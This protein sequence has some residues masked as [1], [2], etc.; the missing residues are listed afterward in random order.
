MIKYLFTKGGIV[1]TKSTAANSSTKLGLHT[2]DEIYNAYMAEISQCRRLEAEEEKLLWIALKN[3][4]LEARNRLFEGNLKLVVSIANKYVNKVRHLKILDIIQEGNLGLLKAIDGFD[5]ELGYAFSTY[6]NSVIENS[7]KTAIDK[8]EYE[9]K[10]SA[11]INRDFRQYQKL[12]AKSEQEGRNKPEDSEFCSILGITPKALE[13]A[14]MNSRF[15]TIS[16]NSKMGE[17][18]DA[19]EFGDTVASTEMDFDNLIDKMV[20]F[21]LLVALKSLLKPEEYYIIY[22]TIL[23]EEKKTNEQV[24]R[25]LGITK[26]AV[27]QRI[28][29]ILKKIKILMSKN[30]NKIT[31]EIAGI[32]KRDGILFEK[33][34]IKPLS[35]KNIT[36]YLY[37]QAT[38][39]ER[40]K[41]FLK[42]ILFGNY[43]YSMQDMALLYDISLDE[44]KTM[45]QEI[46]RKISIKLSDMEKYQSFKNSLIKTHGAKIFY[47]FENDRFIDYDEVKK[48]YENCTYEEIVQ[49]YPDYER[50]PNKVKQLLEN[51]FGVVKP[52]SKTDY[53]IEREVNLVLH[54]YNPKNINLSNEVLKQV[55]Q[56]HREEFTSMEQLYLECIIFRDKNIEEFTS[57]YGPYKQT[58]VHR[59]KYRLINRLERIYYRIDK[60]FEVSI[61]KEQY[62]KIVNEYNNQIPEDIINLLNG[63]F[64]VRTQKLTISQLAQKYQVSEEEMSGIIFEAKSKLQTI[65]TNRNRQIH[66]EKSVYAPFVI[67]RKYEY[68]K[69][70]RE[71]LDLYIIQ[72]KDY[73]YIAGKLNISE[74]N[75]AQLISR[76]IQRI[77][78]YRF[79]ILEPIKIT[80]HELE[81][82][83]HSLPKPLDE[84]MR[85][86]VILR[87]RDYLSNDEISTQL[88][89]PLAKINRLFSN[90]NV[91]YLKY[92]LNNVQIDHKDICVE[93]ERHMS[94]SILTEEEKTIMSLY[95]GFICEYNLEGAKCTEKEIGKRLGLSTDMKRKI[96]TCLNKIKS[97]KIGI[98]RPEMIY[99]LDRSAIEKQ[100]QDPHLPIE[101]RDKDLICRLLG[102]QGYS[103]QTLKQVSQELEE[104]EKNLRRRYQIA[105]VNIN[106]YMLKEIKEKLNYEYDILP[107]LKYFS[108]SDRLFIQEYFKMGMSI[109]EIAKKYKLSKDKISNKLNQIQN[110]LHNILFDPNAPKFDFDYCEEVVTNPDL[111]YYGEIGQVKNIFDLYVG[112]NELLNLNIV[113]IIKRLNLNM[114]A[115]TLKEIIYNFM[116]SICKY[117]DGIRKENTFPIEKV[118]MYYEQY[119]SILSG[120]ERIKFCHYIERYEKSTISNSPKMNRT[121]LYKILESEMGNHFSMRTATKEQVFQLLK[122]HSNSFSNSTR[123]ALMIKF[124][125]TKREFMTGKEMNHVLRIL[126]DLHK[127]LTMQESDAFVKK[128]HT[129][130]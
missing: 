123:R 124:G 84:D 4:N 111:P 12:M 1:M 18:E 58:Q 51:Y 8:I 129:N 94:E 73:K 68:S 69:D 27:N 114:K 17:E 112:Q 66:I 106:R 48:Q 5:V 126:D 64:G 46:K 47:V 121:I 59:K 100:L 10:R 76:G 32:K 30:R 56:K 122:K 74:H 79:Q 105:I 98:L 97:R 26:Q 21:E 108:N 103:Y 11:K 83:F 118:K 31:I 99:N 88:S 96:H 109:E 40:E 19:L 93:I 92:K 128:Y 3:G 57:S 24:A 35:L 71:A 91:M 23:G 101:E 34:K 70:T 25:S 85:Q 50:Q 36:L 86:I 38:L 117:R 39:T 77:D 130:N 28:R 13:K 2:G 45:Y 7:I 78:F 81:Q 107:N 41:I 82:F 44:I 33:R 42:E 29:T 125:I 113:Q 65:Y 37:I 95:I 43:S 63:Y 102:L 20:D 67:D 6:A 119:Q 49:M 80:Y 89:L 22:H 55:Y 87:Y 90:F 61:T 16:L 60:V 52:S 62:I 72:N 15:D 54:G 115:E 9:I 110:R 104:N 116:L 127:K 75:V 14:K 53:E 120:D